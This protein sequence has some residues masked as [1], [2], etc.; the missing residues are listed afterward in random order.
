M[1]KRGPIKVVALVGW[2]CFVDGNKGTDGE[3]CVIDAGEIL[4]TRV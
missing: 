3:V 2:M 4:L 1:V